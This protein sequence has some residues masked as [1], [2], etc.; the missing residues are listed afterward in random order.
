ML[1]GGRIAEPARIPQK[2]IFRCIGCQQYGQ[3]R[4]GG[5]ILLCIHAQFEAA[6]ID[7]FAHIFVV[8]GSCIIFNCHTIAFDFFKQNTAPVVGFAVGFVFV[9]HFRKIVERLFLHVLVEIYFPARHQCSRVIGP[10]F[11]NLVVIGQRSIVVV[12]LRIP[13]CAQDVGIRRFRTNVHRLRNI[14]H[15]FFHL[16]GILVPERSVVECKIEILLFCQRKIVIRQGQILL[17]KRKLTTSAIDI[18][19]VIIRTDFDAFGEKR[20]GACIILCIQFGGSRI[21]KIIGTL[22][23]VE[24]E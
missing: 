11:K 2:G 20:D 7:I 3:I 9:N 4:N 17:A 19:F 1:I 5:F 10:D 15:R 22:L 21:V 12:L 24:R 16:F 8:D 6:T 13:G 14:G 23:R 18:R